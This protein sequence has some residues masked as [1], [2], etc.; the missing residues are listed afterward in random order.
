VR[1]LDDTLALREHLGPGRRLAVVGGGWI[2]TEIAASANQV[3]TDVVLIEA[4]AAPLAAVLGPAMG[5][6][7][8]ALHRE[9]G[10]EVRTGSGV[11]GFE[12][13]SGVQAVRLAGGDLIECDAVAVGV[14]VVPAAELAEHAGLEVANGILVDALLRS[15]DPRILAAGDVAAVDHP[16]Y[17]RLRVEHWENARRQ[18]RAAA[19]TIAGQG[20][21]FDAIPYFFS[22]QYDLG[23]EYTGLASPGDELVI[24]G[25][26]ESREFVAYWLDGGRVTAGMNVNVW[27]VADDIRRLIETESGLDAAS[28]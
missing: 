6:L 2:G 17:G 15:S 7:F 13:T 8:A 25:S 11:A 14:G 21:P 5:E 10:V 12:G 18:G 22:D 19:A 4:S 20:K 3:G 23:M 27:D 24:R 1:T 16:R 28:V 26:L 9:H